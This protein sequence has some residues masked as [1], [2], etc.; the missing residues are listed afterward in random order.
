[1]AGQKM[2]V[3][4]CRRFLKESR[5]LLFWNTLATLVRMTWC[6]WALNF[7]GFETILDNLLEFL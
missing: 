3:P 4:L 6:G 5:I 1:M 7:F 2:W